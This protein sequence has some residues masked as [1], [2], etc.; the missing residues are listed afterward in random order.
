MTKTPTQN[1]ILPNPDQLT[2]MMAQYVK[3]KHQ[4]QDMLLFYQ[5]GEFYELFFDD[6]VLAAKALD[7]ALTKRGQHDGIDIPMCGVPMHSASTYI[8]RLIKKNFRIAICEQQ[9]NPIEA[10]KRGA[11]SVVKRDIVRIITPGTLTEDTLLHQKTNNFLLAVSWQQDSF[12]AARIDIS[13]GDFIVESLAHD[14][15][16]SYLE[17]IK[18]AEV[19]VS[20]AFLQ[21][22]EFYEL[23]Q[24]WKA[25]LIPLAEKN[26]SYKPAYRAL[27]DI[28]QVSTLDS[29][30]QFS[31]GEISAAGAVIDY[32]HITGKGCT[33]LLKPLTK[34]I[35]HQH[36]QID[37]MT[38]KN[39][40][41]FQKLNGSFKGSLISKIDLTITNAGG[42]LLHKH[43]LT[44]LTDIQ[45]I[46]NRLNIIDH[47][48]TNDE[49]RNLVRS[50]LK[51]C[52]DLER[53]LVRLAM[54][55]GGPRDL[56]IIKSGLS[57]GQEL[58][59]CHKPY[60][61]EFQK[62]LTHFMQHEFL[63]QK[64]DQAL[65]DELP[66]SL[67]DGN[68]IAAGYCDELD[69]IRDLQNHSHQL[70]QDLQK[71][72]QEETKIQNLKIKNNNVLGYFVEVK[73][74]QKSNIEN[75]T[76]F[77][78]RQSLASSLR[79]MTIELQELE[80]KLLSA[81]D[82]AHQ[83]ELSLFKS[84]VSEVLQYTNPIRHSAKLIAHIDVSS[85]FAELAHQQNYCRPQ[86]D[87]SEDLFIEKGRHPVVESTL[88]QEKN[89]KFVANNCQMKAQ[90]NHLWLLTGPNM[91]GKSTFLRQNA[92]I[93]I[94]AQVG[95][96]VP[97]DKARIGVVDKLFTR[98]GAGDDL[99]KGHSTFMIEMIETAAILN[100][101]T[102]KSFVILDELGRGTAT[103]DG[104]SI[105]W[106]SLEYLHHHIH[107][108]TLFATH[109]HELCSLTSS[110]PHLSNHTM[111]IKEWEGDI[112]FLHKVQ[113]GS[114]N[115]SF[116]IQVAK[117]AG[118]PQ[119]VLERAQQIL[120][121][122]ESKKSKKI[123]IDQTLP[124]F[125][126][127]KA[128]TTALKKEKL[129]LHPIVKTIEET[130]VDQLT[131]KQALDLLY[132]L[133]EKQQKAS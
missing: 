14:K 8:E 84:L 51:N 90:D 122:L 58:H 87:E 93:I 40:E 17:K 11:K 32:L 62:K 81:S 50:I 96:Y 34:V 38:Y 20:E 92:L 77:I 26:F 3:L 4:Y 107:C 120:K 88:S 112:I 47:Y 54:N 113:P 75:H 60:P 100:Q 80:Q 19:L 98:I 36:I 103:Y 105:A 9:E 59:N 70:I 5:M 55:R 67:S 89:E 42:R 117:R 68:F 16:E 13:T 76:Q 95:S 97:A 61:S 131:P 22:Q 52:P 44:P 15:L 39:L 99:A 91:A 114:L 130:D 49:L 132:H 118:I 85:A 79:Y 45:K 66:A 57:C 74:T 29:F 121:S 21:Q 1:N 123:V 41:V 63:T 73:P 125:E 18:P 33:P 46:E 116:G 25:K 35:S 72:Y 106:A 24:I 110:L 128:P 71:K 37:S 126:T 7:I 86:L 23:F 94:M 82:K 127:Q 28:Y 65:R 31:H 53:A 108:R 133:K 43:F 83:I 102:K 27:L 56:A 115:K 109:Y 129:P 2:P 104:L 69:Q 10:K 30:G 6:A 101:A 12:G 48:K 64:L 78:H 119:N 124:L 111:T